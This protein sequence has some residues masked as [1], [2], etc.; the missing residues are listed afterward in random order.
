MIGINFE[1]VLSEVVETNRQIKCQQWWSEKKTEEQ[2]GLSVYI[3]L[4]VLAIIF[5][6]ILV[7]L[8]HTW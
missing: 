1:M 5:L 6:I 8:L 4:A 2:Y 3:G 7:I